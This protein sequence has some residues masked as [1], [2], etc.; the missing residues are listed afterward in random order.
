M[1][2]SRRSPLPQRNGVDATPVKLPR[3]EQWDTLW[4]YLRERFHAS[5][6]QLA[7]KFR[8]GDIADASGPL[9]AD[10]AFAPGAKIW[11]HREPPAET[12]VPFEVGILHRDEDILVVDKPHFLAT[13]PRGQHV[14]QTA[15]A[16]LRQRLGLPQLVAAHRLDRMTAGVLLLVVNPARRGTYQKLFQQR[17]VHKEY[18]A[19]AGRRST[20][21]FPRVV[22]TRLEKEPGCRAAQTLPGPPNSATEVELLEQRGALGHYRLVPRTGRTHQLRAHMNHLGTPILGDDLYPRVAVRPPGEFTRPL[23]LLASALE[24]TDPVSGRV[25]RFETR[26]HLQAWDDYRAWAAGRWP[27]RA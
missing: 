23:Q 12:P 3:Q 6:E 21:E 27:D 5:A 24:F 22:R 11:I 2:R 7:A 9:G 17:R 14:L 1:A 16:R 4:A 25:R 19:V 18:R 8:A 26:Q 20:A 13:T 15:L 10:A